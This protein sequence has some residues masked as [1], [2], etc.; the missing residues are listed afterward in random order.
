[1]SELAVETRAAVVGWL[2]EARWWERLS[3]GRESV[4]A[5]EL[6]DFGNRISKIVDPAPV[7]RIMLAAGMAGKVAA[8]EAAA[9]DLGGDRAFSGLGRRVSLSAGFDD[10]GTSQIQ[11][12]FR[13]AGLWML[14]ERGRRAGKTIVP[15]RARALSTPQGPRARSTTGG[16]GGKGTYT[17]AVR[18][19]RIV[20]PRAA[21]KAFQLEVAKVVR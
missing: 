20:V 19:A 3:H 2:G 4:V 5:N 21:F 11:L 9:S 13:P 8:T 1:M 10:V 18:D 7:A 17:R 6:I 15:R 14:A 12:N 16:W